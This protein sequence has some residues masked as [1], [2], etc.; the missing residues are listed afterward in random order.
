MQRAL[1]QAIRNDAG[2]RDNV[3]DQQPIKERSQRRTRSGQAEA[4]AEAAA[5]R[6]RKNTDPRITETQ[7]QNTD[8]RITE[9]DIINTLVTLW[10]A[11]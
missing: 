7:T 6:L 3:E 10:R 2:T 11:S 8:P 5:V 4:A 1:S 9:T